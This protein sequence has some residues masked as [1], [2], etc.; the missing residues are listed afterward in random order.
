MR[1]PMYILI[2]LAY[3]DGYLTINFVK[4]VDVIRFTIMIM[5]LIFVHIVIFGSLRNALIITVIIVV[6]GLNTRYHKLCKSSPSE[7]LTS[8][9]SYN[10]NQNSKSISNRSQVLSV[11]HSTEKPRSNKS[12]NMH[13]EKIKY[14]QDM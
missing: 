10:L 5:M 1:N 9:D 8:M 13:S 3:L 7:N 11:S 4:Y 14:F 2:D 12:S 6:K